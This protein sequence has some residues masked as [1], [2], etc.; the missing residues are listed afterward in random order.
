MLAIRRE[1]GDQAL[2]KAAAE[3]GEPARAY[4]ARLL[5]IE[6]LLTNLPSDG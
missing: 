6:D 3:L 2:W 1:E 4:V 5:A